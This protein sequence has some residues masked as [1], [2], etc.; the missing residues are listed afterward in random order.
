M[1]G[2]AGM[3][4]RDHPVS[5]DRT[6]AEVERDPGDVRGSLWGSRRGFLRSGRRNQRAPSSSGRGPDAMPGPRGSSLMGGGGQPARAD[7]LPKARLSPGSTTPGRPS[8]WLLGKKQVPLT[9][10]AALHWGF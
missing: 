4:T 7:P 9:V 10:Q 8:G 5:P 2:G 6:G 3:R 1:V